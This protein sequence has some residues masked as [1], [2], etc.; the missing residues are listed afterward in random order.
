MDIV[1]R[2]DEYVTMMDASGELGPY[3]LLVQAA[4]TIRQ[5]RAEIERMKQERDYEC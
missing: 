1:E 3:N 4:E 2:L 5:L